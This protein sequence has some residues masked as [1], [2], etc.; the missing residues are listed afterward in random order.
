MSVIF[1]GV[2][3]NNLDMGAGRNFLRNV[4]GSTLMG[5][6]LLTALGASRALIAISVGTSTSTRTKLSVLS[7]GAVEI[8]ARALDGEAGSQAISA[9]TLVPSQRYHIAATVDYVARV[10][11]IYL[12][13]VAIAVGTLNITSG[14]TS[15]TAA[16][17]GTVGAHETGTTAPWLG[18]IEDARVYGRVLGPTEILTIAT[19]KGADGITGSL[20]G[21][22]LLNELPVGQ[23]VSLVADLSPNAYALAISGSLVYGASEIVARRRRQSA[24]GRR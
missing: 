9:G 2:A 19:A 17:T 1:D 24:K 4:A 8:R 12:D 13:G 14:N 16:T 21:R 23:A 15:D 11:T 3:A 5:W 22:W 10:A 7:S 6:G 18:Y 20:Q